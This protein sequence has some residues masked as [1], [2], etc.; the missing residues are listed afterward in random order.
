VSVT[1][2]QALPAEG[3][4]AGAIFLEAA[5][6]PAAISVGTRPQFY[7]DGALLVEVHVVGFAGELYGRALDVVFLTRLRD[8]TTFSSVDELVAQIGRDVVKTQQIFDA[9]SFDETILLT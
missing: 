9:E 7:Q 6:W 1:P 8:Q 5:W 2:E 3:V 4:Y